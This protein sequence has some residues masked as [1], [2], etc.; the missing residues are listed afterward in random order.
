VAERHLIGGITLAEG[1]LTVSWE[2]DQIVLAVEKRGER[3]WEVAVPMRRLAE[4][5]LLVAEAEDEV[6]TSRCM[7]GVAY[8]RTGGPAE[9]KRHG[10]TPRPFRGGDSHGR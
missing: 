10:H 3:T 5:R 6:L 8:S 7:G 9:L 4:F 1:T 2:A